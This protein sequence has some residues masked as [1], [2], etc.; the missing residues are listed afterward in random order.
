MRTKDVKQLFSEMTSKG[1][2]PI[3]EINLASY[4]GGEDRY[5]YRYINYDENKDTLQ[6]GTISNSSG[7]VCIDEVK[8]DHDFSFDEN[9]EALFDLFVKNTIESKEHKN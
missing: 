5:V 2:A 1:R 8:Y 7:F 4:L 9:L 3:F 6:Y